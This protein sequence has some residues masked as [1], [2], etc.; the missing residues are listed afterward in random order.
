[1]VRVFTR[2]WEIDF[3]S[4]I[5]GEVENRKRDHYY[6]NRVYS[7]AVIWGC[8]GKNQVTE[9]TKVGEKIFGSNDLTKARSVGATDYSVTNLYPQLLSKKDRS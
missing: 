1:M 9:N 5:G 4:A 8:S 7:L 6:P 3:P 2:A